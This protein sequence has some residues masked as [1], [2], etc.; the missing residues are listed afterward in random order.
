M[1]F[2]KFEALKHRLCAYLQGKDVFIEDLYAGA[3]DRYRIPIRIIAEKAWHA[4][5]ARN[6]FI[7]ELDG[8]RLAQHAPQFTILHARNFN[9]VPEIDGTNSAAFIVLH[10]GKGLI[11]IGGT[12][13]AGEMKKSIFTV[14]NYL[15]PQQRVMPM[16]CSANIGKR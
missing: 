16:H 11:L 7:R 4:L 3:D 6:L 13:Y 5:F 1:E 2:D 9:A 15:L 8:E 10:F 12:A 14:M